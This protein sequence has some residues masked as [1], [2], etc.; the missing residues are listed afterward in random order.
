MSYYTGKLETSGNL[1]AHMQRKLD[2]DCA[3]FVN[4][5]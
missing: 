4:N 3:K 2:R 1:A 5:L